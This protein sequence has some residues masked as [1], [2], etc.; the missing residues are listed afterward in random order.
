MLY[1]DEFKFVK[2]KEKRICYHAT[3]DNEEKQRVKRKWKQKMYALQKHILFDFFEN[4]YVSKNNLN[5]VKKTIFV[6]ENKTVI[7]SS[8]PDE[9]HKAFKDPLHVSVGPI[10]KARS[11]KIKKAL[12]GL[13]QEIW[14]DS[15]MGHSKLSP[16][17]DEDVINL[18]QVI[19][20]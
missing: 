18:I 4:H 16:K 13:I 11:R 20:G 7:R 2:N 17:I 10:T 3:F 12:N 8:H 15:N 9:N 6:K 1:F 5:M 19:E 14:V